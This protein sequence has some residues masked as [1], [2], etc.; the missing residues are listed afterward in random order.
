MMSHIWTLFGIVLF[1]TTAIIILRMVGLYESDISLKD[2]MKFNGNDDVLSLNHPSEIQ[3][4]FY[5]EVRVHPRNKSP[6]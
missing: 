5:Q 2:I 4:S 1:V 6:I 3:E